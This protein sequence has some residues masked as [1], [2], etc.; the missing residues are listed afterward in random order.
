VRGDELT[1]SSA[2]DLNSKSTAAKSTPQ[3]LMVHAKISDFSQI[4]A[5][6]A[7]SSGLAFACGEEQLDLAAV[8]EHMMNSSPPA[9]LPN[10]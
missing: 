1:C 3:Q 5:Q 10:Y 8:S 4:A 6:Q 7:S 2:L 9:P